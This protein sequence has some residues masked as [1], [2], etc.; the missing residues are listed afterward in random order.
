VTREQ[1]KAKFPNATEDFIALN[2]AAPVGGLVA[3]QLQHNPRP[4]LGH[5]AKKQKSGKRGLVA[6][7]TIVKCGPGCADDDNI[8][9]G[10][11]PLR[12]AIATSLGV[13]D[14]DK[15]LR[16]QYRGLDSSGPKGT[17]VIIQRLK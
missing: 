2:S 17:L 1:L 6:V 10:A 4:P 7:V 5:V 9:T 8:G 12:D 3:S 11:K 13:D 16:W 14:G 15:R